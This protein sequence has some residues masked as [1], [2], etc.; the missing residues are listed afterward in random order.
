MLSSL[1]TFV[2]HRLKVRDAEVL[3]PAIELNPLFD[4]AGGEGVVESPTIDR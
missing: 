2:P 1:G 3:A 4:V